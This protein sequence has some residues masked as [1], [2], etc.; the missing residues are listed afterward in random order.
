MDIFLI[1]TYVV[2]FVVACIVSSLIFICVG[3]YL[4]P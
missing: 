1:T 4:W 3:I 2:Y